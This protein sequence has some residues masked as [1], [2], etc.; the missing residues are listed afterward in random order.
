LSDLDKCERIAE[1]E[2]QPRQWKKRWWEAIDRQLP[3]TICSIFGYMGQRGR[4]KFTHGWPSTEEVPI[5]VI[6]RVAINRL[7]GAA[8]EGKLFDLE[9]IPPGVAFH[10]FTVLENMEPE[11]KADFD[12]GIRALNLQLASV[13]AHG[14]V[15]FGMVDVERV[16]TA[17]IE[18][19]V[20]DR[21]VEGELLANGGTV[22]GVDLE[23]VPAF[24]RAL[25]VAH[26]EQKGSLLDGL[27]TL[28]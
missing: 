15:G 20:F 2:S 24:F 25:V 14:T 7:T 21:D 1:R 13:G 4:V 5:D 12:K 17:G 11:Q 10:F 18:P 3:C 26:S 6:T 22:P 16:F 9:A 27:I 28:T 23:K 8:D 19:A